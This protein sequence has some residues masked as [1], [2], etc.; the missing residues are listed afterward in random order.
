MLS[1]ISVA[2]PPLTLFNRM[3][4]APP[5]GKDE[6]TSLERREPKKRKKEPKRKLPAQI[7]QDLKSYLNQL[8]AI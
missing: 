4:N 3:P 8:F 5:E 2:S 7:G 1:F 6:D